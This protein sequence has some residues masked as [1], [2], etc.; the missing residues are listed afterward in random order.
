MGFL[1]D[2]L[3]RLLRRP[4]WYM[5]RADCEEL[6]RESFHQAVLRGAILTEKALDVAERRPSTRCVEDGTAV[7]GD[8]DVVIRHHFELENDGSLVVDSE[9]SGGNL[10]RIKGFVG[11]LRVEFLQRVVYLPANPIR[12]RHPEEI[13]HIGLPHSEVLQDFSHSQQKEQRGHEKQPTVRLHL[14]PPFWRVG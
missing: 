9:N 13:P 11:E 6:T 2:T 12:W 14:V 5:G 8:G 3:C 7:L 4:A 10:S 1:F